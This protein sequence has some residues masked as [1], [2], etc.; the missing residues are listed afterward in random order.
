MK[1]V[2][3]VDSCIWLNLFKKEGDEKKGKPYWKIARDFLEMVLCDGGIIYYSRFV[4]KEI[5]YVLNDKNLYK[6]KLLF[7]KKGKSFVYVKSL[8][9]DYFLAR[10]I[11][12]ETNYVISFFDCLHMATSKRKGAVLVTRDNIFINRAKKYV[13]AK[14]P[15][16]L[17][18]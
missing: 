9:E 10:R 8:D 14:K 16:D 7:L 1:N 11:E 13:I 2:Y 4:L 15:E 5:E 12:C 18:V 17:L 6:E 3:Y